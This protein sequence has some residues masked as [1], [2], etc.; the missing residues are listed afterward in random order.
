MQTLIN[1]VNEK[2]VS[3]SSKFSE[4]ISKATQ[5]SVVVKRLNKII[6]RKNKNKKL[7]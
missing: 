6:R 1:F 5:M 3:S 7:F 4:L 2:S